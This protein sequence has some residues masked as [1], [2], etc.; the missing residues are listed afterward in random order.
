MEAL[1]KKLEENQQMTEAGNGEP[2]KPSPAKYV[3]MFRIDGKPILPPLVRK[4]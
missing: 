3:S 2:P 4:N 1:L